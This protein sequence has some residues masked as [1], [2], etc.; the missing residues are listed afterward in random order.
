MEIASFRFMIGAVECASVS[1][2]RGRFRAEAFFA[3]VPAEDLQPVLKRYGVLTEKIDTPLNCLLFAMDDTLALV[4]TGMGGPGSSYLDSRLKALGL[5]RAD[6]NMVILS[7]AHGDH[8]GGALLPDGRPAFPA[9][10]YVLSQTE[11]D[12]WQQVGSGDPIHALLQALAPQLELI[13]AH[14]HLFEGVETLP[15]PGHTPGQIG[16]KIVSNGETLLYTADV[17]AHPIHLEYCAWNIIS[18][19]DRTTALQ[20]R[21]QILAQAASEGWQLFVYHFPYSGLYQIEPHGGCWRM[22]EDEA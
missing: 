8:A 2:G 18:D 5:A 9:A 21:A 19:V 14:T 16:V 6:I 3:N 1:A 4:D 17:V 7:H 11:W 10:R 12:Y 20:T 15:L 13:P 22:V